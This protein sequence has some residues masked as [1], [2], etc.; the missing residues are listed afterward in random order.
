VTAVANSA[1]EVRGE[2][3]LEPT[4][5]ADRITKLSA[6]FYTNSVLSE[7]C[8]DGEPLRSVYIIYIISYDLIS[9]QPNWSGQGMLVS[10]VRMSLLWLRMHHIMTRHF[11]V[12]C[13]VLIPQVDTITKSAGATSGLRIPSHPH[14]TATATVPLGY[15]TG[16]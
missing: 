13:R 8:C 14:S 1:T 12:A 2:G 6:P 4:L 10:S 7:P 15:G 5:H 16:I 3:V 9:S 11:L